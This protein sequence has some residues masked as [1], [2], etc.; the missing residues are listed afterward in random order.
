MSIINVRDYAHKGDRPGDLVPACRRAIEA[1]GDGDTLRFPAGEHEL[2]Q[3]AA[4]QTLLAVTNHDICP[5]VHGILLRDKRD[6]TIDGQGATLYAHGLVSPLWI[7]GCRNVTVR[8]I[9]FDRREF[10]NG[11]GVVT[12]AGDGWMDLELDPAANPDWFVWGGILTFQS[13]YWRE[14]LTALFEWDARERIPAPGSADNCGGDWQV[15]WTVEQLGD[16]RLRVRGGYSHPVTVGNHMMLRCGRRYAPG[17][18]MS[19][20]DDIVCENVAVHA[21]GGMAF[22]AQRCRD[23]TLRKCT[24]AP[25]PRGIRIDA[26]AHDATHFAN[27]A[28]HVLIEGCRFENQLDDPT[29]VHG[30]YFPVVRAL[31]AHT[32]R[33]ELGH[34]QQAGAPVG[35]AGDRFEL[36]ARA[37]AEAYWEGR[38]A[39]VAV[40][41]LTTVD[42]RFEEQL[43]GE[44]P[45]G[46]ALD[47]IDWYPDLTMR[48][49]TMRGNRARG[50]L[51]STRG[52]TL[53][54]RNYIYSPGA[55][56]QMM[57]GIGNWYE[58]G[59]V[60]DCVIRDNHLDRCAYNAPLWG[61]APF[62][63][64]AECLDYSGRT[65][66]Y[67]RNIRIENNRITAAHDLVLDLASVGDCSFTGNT[68]E[69]ADGKPL[70]SEWHRQVHCRNVTIAENDIR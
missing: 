64:K 13:R 9:S 53:I 34:V 26:D 24:V 57:G 25:T 27:C 65:R 2:Y 18:T 23:V 46:D 3:E 8:D 11:M 58:S 5:R 56:I 22:I 63:F 59:P 16:T 30:A 6:I 31:D 40:V 28:G 15:Q 17:V 42:V 68:I 33:V 12:A 60:F 61:S 43:P 39:S 70:G 44:V 37:S 14:Q 51:V 19:R 66:P 45:A 41:N 35:D 47:N 7:E 29:N 21:C 50:P 10:L 52:K 4:E 62:M 1:L 20:S 54:E 38:A 67:H 49:C 55:G 48:D 36:C 32:L 69:R